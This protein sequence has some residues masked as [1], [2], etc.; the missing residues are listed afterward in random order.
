M[1]HIHNTTFL[2]PEEKEKFF[3][4]TIKEKILPRL[5]ERGI[6][7]EPLFT[8]VFV[9]EQDGAGFSLQLIFPDE[10]EYRLFMEKHCERLFDEIL[11][12]ISKDTLY[13]SSL[14]KEIS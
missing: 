8:R 4:D 9:E 12:A 7:V 2:L 5:R 10:K 1:R 13:F 6:V 14:L 3:V 11:A